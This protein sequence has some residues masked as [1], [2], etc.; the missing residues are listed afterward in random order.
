MAKKY[1]RNR[2]NA[3]NSTVSIVAITTPLVYVVTYAI[4]ALLR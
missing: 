1:R 4:I 3:H 2:P